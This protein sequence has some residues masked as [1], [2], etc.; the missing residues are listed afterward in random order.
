M[1]NEANLAKI[2]EMIGAIEVAMLTTVRPDG[3]LHARPMMTQRTD[4]DG[5]LW[6][7]TQAETPKVNEA[8]R[9]EQVSLSYAC[10]SK[11]HY[12]AIAGKARLVRDRDKIKELW[13]APLKAWF[14][15]G[16]EGPGVALLRVEVEKA[17]YW[18]SSSSAVVH[19]VGLVKAL[20]TGKPYKPGNNEK[21]DLK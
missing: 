12:V 19:L 10:P 7:F 2:A 6:F 1:S 16:P 9:E 18:D 17:E 11:Q 5:V 21:V 15:Q 14:P 13:R 3:S 20:V 8:E 4:F